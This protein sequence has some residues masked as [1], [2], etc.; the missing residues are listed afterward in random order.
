MTR[1]AAPASRCPCA[2]SAVPAP[3]LQERAA[4]R[5][6]AGARCRADEGFAR[7]YFQRRRQHC[8]RRATARARSTKRRR[9]RTRLR[10][11]YWCHPYPNRPPMRASFSGFAREF[12]QREI[13]AISSRA[14]N[15]RLEGA[16][17]VEPDLL[18]EFDD[19]RDR[20]APQLFV[21]DDAA[22]ADLALAAF[23]LRLDQC[24]FFG[25]RGGPA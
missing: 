8:A 12:H 21:L 14:F 24:H 15:W 18:R 9:Q 11:G 19:A 16:D 22:L 17:H 25:G 10:I 2:R 1:R 23:E 20:F 3:P 7:R 4:I 5:V 6:R 13:F